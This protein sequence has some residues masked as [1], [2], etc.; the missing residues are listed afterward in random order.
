MFNR[1]STFAKGKM[2]NT[3]E[4]L[5]V[6]YAAQRINKGYVKFGSYDYHKN[7]VLSK[8]N[9]EI[10]KEHFDCFHGAWRRSEH[11]I[12]AKISVLDEDK[13][14]ADNARAHFK[15]YTIGLLGNTLNDFQKDLFAAVSA[16]EVS[17]TELGILAYVPEM[18][19]RE[20]A[21][22]Q[23]KKTVKN[24]F[25]NSE[26]AGAIG[27]KFDGLCTII[28]KQFHTGYERYIYTVENNGNIL[29]FFCK[30]EFAEGAKKHISGKI[31]ALVQNKKYKVNETRLNYVK[32]LN[33]QN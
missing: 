31:K 21:D 18:I 11:G 24:H 28:S 19:K 5:A 10:V 14:A 3:L 33:E 23:L 7:I 27:D 2:F 15:K 1:S 13:H 17:S 9:K 6:A 25:A 30:F 16:E 22:S 32:V 12:N 29:S 8:A 26:F 4:V 20:Q